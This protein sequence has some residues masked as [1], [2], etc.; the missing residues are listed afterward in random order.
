MQPYSDAISYNQ[1]RKP[2]GRGGTWFSL[3]LLVTVG[4]GFVFRQQ[5]TDAYRLHNYV[6]PAA[7]AQLA[8]QDGLQPGTRRV[9]FVNHPQLQNKATFKTACPNGGG[10]TTII[11]GCYHGGQNGIYLLQVS[12]S[13]LDGVT[14]VTAAHEALH[15]AYDRLS[16]SE[17]RKVDAMLLDYY[18]H[19]LQDQR[20]KDTVDGYKKT[21]PKDVIN[22]MHSIF[23][24]EITTLPKDLEAYYSRYF[25]DRTKV[26]TFANQYQAEFSSRQAAVKQDDALLSTLKQR[27]DALEANLNTQQ[28]QITSRQQDL[29]AKRKN[30]E[31]AAYNAGVPGYN[32]LIE[33]YNTNVREVQ[34]LVSQYNELVAARNDIAA[35]I[36]ELSNALSSTATQINQ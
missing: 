15:A 7:I 9:F 28:I 14:Q 19:G 27:I 10:E 21:E 12:D 26:T 22:E 29:V 25:I 31:T 11:L 36:S 35:Q 8:A 20:I 2:Q 13:R 5:L 3:A 32:A 24:T 17:R 6:P 34:K 1:P 33:T 4:L 18:N 23:G 30:G 16:K